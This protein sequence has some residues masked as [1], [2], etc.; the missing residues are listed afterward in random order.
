MKLNHINLPVD[1]V[2][3][4]SQFFERF[5]DFECLEVK[6]D[7]ALAVLKGEGDFILVLMSKAFNKNSDII[8]P[9]AFHIGFLVKS[10]DQVDAAYQRL[11]AGN[12]IPENPPGRLR[13]QYGF[14]FKGPGNL[15]I[16][17]TSY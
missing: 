6:G 10:E 1:D 2:G 7:N 3:I 12:T 16:E 4:T 9:D 5:F 8:Y 15:L 17:V 11:I 14:Y 13:G